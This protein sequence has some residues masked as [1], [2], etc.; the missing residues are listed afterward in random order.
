MLSK[1]GK[2]R[3]YMTPLDYDNISV[4]FQISMHIGSLFLI[5]SVIFMTV[6]YS[7][8]GSKLILLPAAMQN[9]AYEVLH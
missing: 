1:A 9:S 7:W 8:S 2:I 3:A 5:F 6:S 4:P